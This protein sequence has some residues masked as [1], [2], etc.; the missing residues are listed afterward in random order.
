MKKRLCL[1]ACIALATLFCTRA[2]R[3]EGPRSR[4]LCDFNWR[5]SKTDPP[6]AN[7]PAFDDSAW[8]TIDL[9]HDFAIRGPF[10]E[11]VPGGMPGG[12]RPLGIGWYRKTFATPADFAGRRLWLDFEGVYRA[13]KVWVNGTLVGECLNGYHG[14]QCDITAC[15]KPAGQTNVVD[16]QTDVQNHGP[17]D[18]RATLVSAVLDPA[19]KAVADARAEVPLHKGEQVT[20]RQQLSVLTPVLWELSHPVLYR[21]VSSVLVA[22]RETDRYETPFGIREIRVTPDGLFLNGKRTLVKGF[23]IHHDLGCLGAAAFDRAIE[24]RLETMQEIGCNG[25]PAS[26]EL[27]QADRRSAFQGRALLVI[28]STRQPGSI[29]AK[30]TADGL[31]SATLALVGQNPCLAP[32]KPVVVPRETVLP[33]HTTFSVPGAKPQP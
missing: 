27:F 20:A 28:R 6:G 22:G 26:D 33:R 31:E 5:L 7:G 21:L 29:T 30:A 24:R 4:E 1:I 10:D 18:R 16:V 23:C 19:G 9:P 11:K 15:L 12:F 2:G 8:Q 13:P 14:F 25:D 32:F 17:A 3:T